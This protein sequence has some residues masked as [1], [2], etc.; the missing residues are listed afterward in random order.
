MKHSHEFR[1]PIHNFIS[2]RSDERKIIDSRPFQRLRNIHQLALSYLVY[3]GATHKRFEHSLG[4][5]ELATRIFDVVT[6]DANIRHDSVRDIMPDRQALDYW[7]SVV[8]AAALC[9]DIGHL[10][11][12]HAAEDEL[13]PEGYDHERLTVDLIRTSDLAEIWPS[14][15]PPLTVDHI[16]KVAVGP[17]KLKDLEFT[18]WETILSE[19]ITGNAFG[20]DRMD[21]LL[22]DAYHTGVA[23]GRYDHF[24]LI[25]C[26]TILPRED[27]ESDEPAL[28]LMEGGVQASEGLMLARH[29]MFKQVYFH[30]VRRAY[31]LHLKEF[32]K[33]WLPKGLFPVT[34]PEH[35][36]LSDAEVLSAI[37]EAALN[38][39]SKGHKHAKRID[40]RD[41]FKLVFSALPSDR[42]S[43]VIEPGEVIAASAA[44]KFGDD[45][46]RHDRVR[47]KAAAHNFPVWTHGKKVD[48]SLKVSDILSKLPVLEIDTVYCDRSIHTECQKWLGSQRNQLLKPSTLEDPS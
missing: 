11:F 28:G 27:Q 30:H 25:Q 48:S 29:F 34:G 47:P 39:R 2:L 1:D 4:V 38:K 24:R 37:R 3:P 9:H 33:N 6:H 5:M 16:V 17:K 19:I 14:L 21:Y 13:L 35:L 31:D 20:A 26:L 18:Q 45:L 7:R 22:R 12:S 8:R 40:C 23:Y 32:L 44:A 42:A 43:G 15:T 41:H 46:I 10:P 36:K